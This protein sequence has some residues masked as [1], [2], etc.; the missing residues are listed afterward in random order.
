MQ[1]RAG[2]APAP[3]I[4]G[5]EGGVAGTPIALSASSPNLQAGTAVNYAWTFSGGGTGTGSS[6][7]PVF[8]AA[9]PASATV[10]ASTVGEC[11]ASATKQ[12]VI[13]PVPPVVRPPITIDR[14]TNL[15][16]TPSTFVAAARGGSV[17]AAR[18]GALVTYRGSQPAQIQYF[19]QRRLTGRRVGAKCVKPTRGNARRR[20]CIRYVAAGSFRRTDRAAGNVRFR[21]T[22]RVGGRKLAVGQYR[23]RVV[24]KN[25][26]GTGRAVL[27]SF[28]I[29]T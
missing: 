25:S 28:R 16:I 10:T 8:A 4:A 20:A 24:P 21:F 1:G 27:A 12:L 19:V 9:G 17:A 6:V 23:L 13:T 7:S 26:A 14:I 2:V 11:A 15:K 22:G 5:P 3:V 18:T 29:R